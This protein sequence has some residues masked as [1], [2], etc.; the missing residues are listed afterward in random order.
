MNKKQLMA[1][2]AVCSD[3]T[4]FGLILPIPNGADKE[5]GRPFLHFRKLEIMQNGDG[6]CLAGFVPDGVLAAI[7]LGPAPNLDMAIPMP[8]NRDVN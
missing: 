5:K 1:A 7:D 6:K 2:L 3:D 4:E 8:G